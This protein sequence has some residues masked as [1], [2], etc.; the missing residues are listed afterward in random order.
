ME[1]RSVLGSWC[2]TAAMT[3]SHI[4]PRRDGMQR[5]STVVWGVME[6]SDTAQCE[7]ERGESM[8]TRVANSKSACWSRFRTGGAWLSNSKAVCGRNDRKAWHR[9]AIRKSRV[10]TRPQN[11]RGVDAMLV[12]FVL[13]NSKHIPRRDILST[14]SASVHCERSQ[15]Y[16]VRRPCY[17]TLWRLSAVLGSKTEVSTALLLSSTLRFCLKGYC[18]FS[19]LSAAPIQHCESSLRYSV[20][21]PTSRRPCSCHLHSDFVWKAT[22]RSQRSPLLL[23]NI[24]KA[25]CDTGFEDWRLDGPAAAS[26]HCERSVCVY[27]FVKHHWTCCRSCHITSWTPSTTCCCY[28]CICTSIAI[29]WWIHD[30]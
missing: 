21:R 5:F 30:F 14:F 11:G 28:C 29:Y 19:T 17:S 8:L 16:S 25:L 13:Y 3:R 12:K 4:R 22:V 10:R 18:T 9:R 20:R 2:D 24:V 15:R 7:R 1:C 6:C 23:F 27:V 26:P